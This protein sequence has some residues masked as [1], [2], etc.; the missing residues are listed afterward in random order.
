MGDSFPG[1]DAKSLDVRE[2]RRLSRSR[3]K[4]E[5]VDGAYLVLGSVHKVFPTFRGTFLTCSYL[6]VQFCPF[7]F[8]LPSHPNQKP[9]GF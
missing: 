2:S 8:L 6:H 3:T 1:I 4:G 5:W 7:L 9:V